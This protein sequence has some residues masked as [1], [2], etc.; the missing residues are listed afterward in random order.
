MESGGRAAWRTGVALTAAL[1][2]AP[3]HARADV[4]DMFGQNEP[5]LVHS[6]GLFALVPPSGWNCQQLKDSSVECNTSNGPQPG[7]LTITHQ[8]VEGQPDCELMALNA[9]SALKR[10]PHYRRTGGGR[11]LLGGV[12]A[13]IRSF[14]FDYQSNTEYPVAVE[15]LY[16]V[17]GGKAIRLHFETMSA[18]MPAYMLDLKKVYDTFGVAEVDVLG[19][20][21]QGARP[22]NTG[23]KKKGRRGAGDP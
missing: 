6:T 17:S 5:P 22:R 14:T 18:A 2:G 10:L 8:T 4:T 7:V 23:P 19:Q 21:V 9:E 13:A 1:L 11:F 16:V 12:K 20:V 3:A 15:E